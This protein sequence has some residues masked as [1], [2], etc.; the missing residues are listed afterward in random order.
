MKTVVERIIMP[1]KN[2][3]DISADKPRM[4]SYGMGWRKSCGY[5]APV[6]GVDRVA[7]HYIFCLGSD[8]SWYSFWI[9]GQWWE[10]KSMSALTWREISANIRRG[11]LVPDDDVLTYRQM[12][13]RVKL[14]YG[15][16]LGTALTA[17]S[18][19]DLYAEFGAIIETCEYSSIQKL[20]VTDNNTE[21][22]LVILCAHK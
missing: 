10:A 22:K 7:P 12:M 15:R 1:D 9:A 17:I 5:I 3:L 16:S 2:P 4:S 13:D 18:K 11:H 8:G 21:Q 20:A 14:L 19:A 6:D